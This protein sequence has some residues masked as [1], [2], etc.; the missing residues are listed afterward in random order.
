MGNANEGERDPNA[1]N[2]R[3][4]CGSNRQSNKHAKTKTRRKMTES[5]VLEEYGQMVAEGV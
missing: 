1:K 4:A 5:V 3:F 2:N